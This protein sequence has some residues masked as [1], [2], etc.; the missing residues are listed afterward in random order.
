MF[1]DAYVIAA[2]RLKRKLKDLEARLHKLEQVL[3][4]DCREKYKLVREEELGE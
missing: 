4:P 3:C 2:K 1:G